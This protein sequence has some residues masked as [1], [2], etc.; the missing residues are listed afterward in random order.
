M[1]EGVTVER[2]AAPVTLQSGETRESILLA[3]TLHLLHML[4]I[5]Q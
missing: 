3:H 5:D 4:K 2:E 1:F